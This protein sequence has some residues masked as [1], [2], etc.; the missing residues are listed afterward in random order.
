[1]AG[2]AHTTAR[3]IASG[4]QGSKSLRPGSTPDSHHLEQT[5]RPRR[6]AGASPLPRRWKDRLFKGRGS[7]EYPPRWNSR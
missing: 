5:T 6:A 2:P 7:Q 4:C 3:N 1:M